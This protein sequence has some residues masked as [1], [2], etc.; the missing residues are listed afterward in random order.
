MLAGSGGVTSS[1]GVLGFVVAAA[2]AD[3][4]DIILR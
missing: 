1:I 2:L 3:D 4:D